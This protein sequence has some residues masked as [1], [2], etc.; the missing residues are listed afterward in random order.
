M[1]KFLFNITVLQGDGIGAEVMGACIE[2][3]EHLLADQPR[4][5]LRYLHAAGGAQHY[6]DTGSAMPEDTLRA[7]ADA[8]AILFGA[9]GLPHIR[10]PDGTEVSPQLDLRKDLDLYAGVRPIRAIPGVPSVLADPRAAQIDFVL[11]REQSEGLFFGRLYPEKQP[12]A[13]DN[14]AFDLGRVSRQASERLFDFAFQLARRRR[15]ANPGKGRVTCVDKANVLSSM[16]F[17]HKIYWE[18]AKL[19]ADL[20]ADHCYVDAMALNLVKRPWDYD[21]IPTENQFGDILS[22]LAAGLIGGLGMSPSADIGDKHGLFQP[23]HGTAP[24]IAGQGK[25]N[26][27]AMILSAALMLAWLGEKHGMPE[28][29]S[30]AARL[31]LAVDAAFA[32]GRIRS[33]ELGG[34][35]GTQ[36]ITGAIVNALARPQRK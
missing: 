28:A 16:A 29:A 1:T 30:E 15:A 21:V 7:C 33:I 27:T 19:N 6:A 11:V 31:T 36:A 5:G 18:R 14:E 13:N 25:A 2:V 34:K 32:S 23:S 9:M 22:D 10:Y 26:P 8:D 35:D 24:D 17:F 12:K 4:F 3:L 20:S